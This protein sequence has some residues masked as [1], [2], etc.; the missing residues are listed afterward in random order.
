[1]S[2]RKSPADQALVDAFLARVEALTPAEWGRLEARGAR[3]ASIT[4]LDL[5]KRAKIDGAAF[6]LWHQFSEDV[7]TGVAL[8]GRAAFWTTIVAM[9]PLMFLAD[10]RHER[11][12]RRVDEQSR[13]MQELED[14]HPEVAAMQKTFKRLTAIC[15]RQPREDEIRPFGTGAQRALFFGLLALFGR[16]SSSPGAF[17]VVYGPVEPVIPFSSLAANTGLSTQT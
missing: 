8:A 1:M 15:D 4:P 9:A 3:L 2:M 13:R 16:S 6:G 7:A 12:K 17:E 14:R 11:M 10:P 5:L